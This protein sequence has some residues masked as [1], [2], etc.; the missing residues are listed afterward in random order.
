[1][2][3]VWIRYS[4]KSALEW[5]AT[6]HFGLTDRSAKKFLFATPSI[7]YASLSI[8]AL[9]RGHIG[10]TMRN[11]C[12]HPGANFVRPRTILSM[13]ALL[14][15]MGC[16]RV[17]LTSCFN[18][19]SCLLEWSSENCCESTTRQIE[20]NTQCTNLHLSKLS[21]RSARRRRFTTANTL[22]AVI[23]HS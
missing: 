2:R 4:F 5:G 15:S 16:Q 11:R 6:T 8:T 21:T 13:G 22:D 1:M 17:C 23:V 10:C 14:L 12:R 3:R 20:I 18:H 9:L 7:F 19:M